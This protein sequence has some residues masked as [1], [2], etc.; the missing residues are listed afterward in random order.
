V[1]VVFAALAAA[2]A[3]TF[4]P[5][6]PAAA[7]TSADLAAL[8]TKMTTEARLHSMAALPAPVGPAPWCAGCHPGL[9]HPGTGVDSAMLN[10]HAGRMDCLLCHW[11]AAGGSRPLP[12]WQ[13]QA[14]AAP[15]LA[16]VP[17]ERLSN[18][19]LAALRTAVTAGRRCFERGPSCAG[20]HRPG[21]IGTLVRPDSSPARVA[22]LGRLEVHFTLAPGEKWYFPRIK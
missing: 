7:P 14:G 16:V 1:F 11:S 20:C 19:R 15:Y 3:A 21:E 22:A 18:D 12:A 6:A 10:E 17:R 4:I 2:A 8:E 5:G 9:P 13:V